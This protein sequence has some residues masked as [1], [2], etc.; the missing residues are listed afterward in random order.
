[1]RIP[2]SQVSTDIFSYKQLKFECLFRTG[3]ESGGAKVEIKKTNILRLFP[4]AAQETVKI[5]RPEAHWITK[6]YLCTSPEP[7]L[8]EPNEI[9]KQN[10][11]YQLESPWDMV[12]CV[13]LVK[14]EWNFNYSIVAV[15]L[16]FLSTPCIIPDLQVLQQM[17]Q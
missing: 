9:K 17:L 8:S 11:N 7:A 14:N 12:A 5:H 3:L 1:M 15:V 13:K 16:T 10:C 2:K 4:N 6:N